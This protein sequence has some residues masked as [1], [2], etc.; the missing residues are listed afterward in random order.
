MIER[1]VFIKLKDEHSTREGR[2]E[3]IDH[4]RAVLPAIPGVQSVSVGEPA[5]GH[6][7]AAWDVGIVVRFDDI[8]AVEPYRAHADHRAYVDEFLK[9]RMAVIKAWNFDL[10]V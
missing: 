1:Y 2:R 9:P 7:V 4:S 3:V 10:G 8:A 5:D 6:A